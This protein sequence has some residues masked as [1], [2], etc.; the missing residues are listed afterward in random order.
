MSWNN[1]KTDAAGRQHAA[2]FA[3]HTGQIR[4]V[5]Q[6]IR[7]ENDVDTGIGQR[8]RSAVVVGNGENAV[9]GIVRAGD[10][11]RCDL[12]AAALEFQRLLARPRPEVENAGAGR[13]KPDNLFDFRKPDRVEVIERQHGSTNTGWY[14]LDRHGNRVAGAL[15]A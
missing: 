15:P 10:V 2:Y 6:H 5:L 3:M 14:K 11:D 1:V 4:H 12:E 13:K 9:H 7:G 8:N